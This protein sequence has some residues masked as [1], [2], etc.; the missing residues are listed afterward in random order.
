[1]PVPFAPPGAS[2]S[3]CGGRLRPV[4]S[5]HSISGSAAVPASSDAS[6]RIASEEVQRQAEEILST[7]LPANLLEDM[8]GG[9]DKPADDDVVASLPLVKIEPYVSLQITP[10]PSGASDAPARRELLADA[11]ERRAASGSVSATSVSEPPQLSSEPTEKAA[12]PSLLTPSRAVLDFKGT[13]SAFGTPLA[14]IGEAG[15]TY[16]S[17][18][19]GVHPTLGWRTLHYAPRCHADSF[20]P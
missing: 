12:E 19:Q 16:P 13:G 8:A 5:H 2:C 15:E 3:M 1:M 10:A 7:I 20:R 4:G 11:A 18:V 6:E 9:A 14:D 17:P